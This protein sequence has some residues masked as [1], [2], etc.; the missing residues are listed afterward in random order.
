MTSAHHLAL[1]LARPLVDTVNVHL[2]SPQWA[3]RVVSPL[4]DVL[5]DNE[6]RAILAD[7]PDSYLHVTS[8]PLALPEPPGDV[9][10]ETVQAKA[11]QRLLDLGA[12]SPVPEPAMFVYRLTDRGREH[13][14]VIAGVAVEGFGDDRVLGHERVQPERVAG[15][16]RHYRRVS[17]RSELVA[18]FHAVDA[19]IAELMTRVV[20]QPPLRS[21]TDAGGMGQSVWQVGPADAAALTRQLGDQ[22]LYLADG[23]HRV[24][25][26]IRFWELAGRPKT[27]TVLCALYPQDEIVLHAFHRRVRGP[28]DVPALLEGLT[29]DFDV[30]LIDSPSEEPGPSDGSRVAPGEIGLYAAGRWW[31][32][33]PREPR[34]LPGVAGLDVT[35]LEQQVLGPLL[36]IGQGDPRLEFVPDLRDLGATTHECVADAGVLFTLHAPRI[37]DVV[38]VAERH[39]VMS[40]KTTY[41]QPKPR[42][43]IFLS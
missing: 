29:A 35:M 27:G 41:V 6:R 8:D 11:L 40:P 18:L 7:N 34:R 5:S 31:R 9:A 16:V 39:E 28:V 33:R 20:A 2:V 36:G 26:A 22:R 24:A 19:V 4:H 10:A 37:K 32:F 23:H 1:H 17:M 12:Y 15:L 21:F 38:S 25:A 3:A 43:G 30:T 14:G 42:S 13:T